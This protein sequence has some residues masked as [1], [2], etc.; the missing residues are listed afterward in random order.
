VV[1]GENGPIMVD[2]STFTVA[3]I[4]GKRSSLSGVKYEC[5]LGPPWL[6]TEIVEGL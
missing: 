5:E 1:R 2:I 3:N 6:A 4:L